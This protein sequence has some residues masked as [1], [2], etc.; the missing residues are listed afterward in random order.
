MINSN[1][2]AR[3]QKTLSVLAAI[4]EVLYGLF[5]YLRLALQLFWEEYG[6]QIHTGLAVFLLFVFDVSTETF[7]FGR[8]ARVAFDKWLAQRL[9]SAFFRLV[10]IQ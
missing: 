5:S 6:Q 2:N 9:D 10:D 3:I 8:K 1:T 4:W 7:A